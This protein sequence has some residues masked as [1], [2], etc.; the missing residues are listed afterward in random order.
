MRVKA[1]GRS[2][3]IRSDSGRHTLSQNPAPSSNSLHHN[4]VTSRPARIHH[5]DPL[6]APN[7]PRFHNLS[8]NSF[9]LLIPCPSTSTNIRHYV[10]LSLTLTTSHSSTTALTSQQSINFRSVAHL[11]PCF[12]Y[13][14]ESTNQEKHRQD[15]VGS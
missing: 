11:R 5:K 10:Q 14:S 12:L 3:Q 13:N 6:P 8:L 15:A 4:T 9:T 2:Y 7:I 1:R